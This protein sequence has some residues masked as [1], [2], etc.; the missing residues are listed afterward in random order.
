MYNKLSQKLKKEK[1]V[2]M[3]KSF[4]AK[5]SFRFDYT[6]STDLTYLVR[7]KYTDLSVVFISIYVWWLT[8][9]KK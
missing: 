8:E 5:V 1:F 6:Y 2:K 7:F 9:K 4:G 3:Q